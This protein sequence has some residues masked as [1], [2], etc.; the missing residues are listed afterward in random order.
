[1]PFFDC[2]HQKLKSDLISYYLTNCTTIDLMNAIG[3]F[4]TVGGGVWNV[5]SGNSATV[6]GGNTNT[7]RGE[8]STV[9][10]GLQNDAVNRQCTIAGE[11]TLQSLGDFRLFLQT[12]S[13]LFYQ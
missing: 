4:S 12:A 3:N 2:L 7:A 13:R 11:S 1:M 6:S 9:S 8:Y 5:A 10:G